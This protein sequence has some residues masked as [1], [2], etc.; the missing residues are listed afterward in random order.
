MAETATDQLKLINLRAPL[1]RVPLIVTIALALFG[2][3][4][5]ARWYI[6]NTMA[7]FAPDADEGGIE[8]ARSAIG[9]A[10]GDP[11]VYLA[12][13][14]LEMSTL[15]PSRRAEAVRLYE[16]SVRLSPNDY[17][18]WLA[19]GRAREQTG[20][21][22]GGEKA[23]R[24][25]IELA[26]AYAYPRWYLGNLLLRAGRTD[27]AFTELRR[28]AESNPA[29]FRPLIFDAAWNIYDKDVGAIEHV[30]G[31][32]AGV[33]AQLATFLATH[34]RA[35]DA[36]RLWKSLSAK[37]KQAERKTG[38]DLFRALFD[39]KQYRAAQELA[40]D[41]GIESG[42]SV[43]R[44]ANGGFENVVSAPGASL[45]G[46]QIN[47]VAQTE[48]AVDSGQHHSGVRS[49]RIIFD[50][51][52]RPGYYNI[53]QLVV[54][55]PATRYRFEGYVRTQDLKSGGTPLIE[56]VNTLD[57]KILGTSQAFPLGRNDWQPVTIEF[58]TP[59]DT[60]G[61]YVRTNRAFC[62]EVCPIFGIIW[63]D[64]FNL[65]RLG[66]SSGAGQD[67]R[68]GRDSSPKT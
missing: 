20:D 56:V 52:S 22:A 6:G 43:G 50:G 46:W 7:D 57:N 24:R 48:V 66:Q 27:E 26:P 38:E 32:G 12:A 39:K 4:F 44:F 68:A 37:E 42:E 35:E 31:E 18:L 63:Y 36:V 21:S 40:R 61:I 33:R 54:V 2:A 1:V 62:G 53:T 11:L 15:D 67:S 5:A 47:S 59:A 60:E 17:R 55:E 30:V 23:L 29:A 45:F 16:Q 41:L 25:A 64:D 13:A 19:L 8:T 65:E 3:W 34:Q 51:F 10:P 49:L 9:F 14:N 28:A 58:S